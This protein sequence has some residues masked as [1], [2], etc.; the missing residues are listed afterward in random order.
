MKTLLILG[1]SLGLLGCAGSSMPEFPDIKKHYVMLVFGG[2]AVCNECDIISKI[3]YKIGNCDEVE[4]QR[5]HLMG[6]YLPA[7]TQKLSNWLVDVK[8]WAE[9]QD[10]NRTCV[11]NLPGG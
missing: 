6:G 7:D 9:K 1:I 3:P 4:L 2:Q 8:Q 5:C 11:Q 10:K